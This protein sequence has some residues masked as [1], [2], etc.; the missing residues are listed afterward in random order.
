MAYDGQDTADL[1]ARL[2][3]ELRDAEP[4]QIL[5]AAI[6]LLGDRLALVSSFGAESAVLLHMAAAL[7]P[8]IP[9]L[10]LHKRPHG[11]NLLVSDQ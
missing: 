9:V 8:D 2:N 1:A 7:K 3:A 10:F 5:S 4:Q 11:I 6:D